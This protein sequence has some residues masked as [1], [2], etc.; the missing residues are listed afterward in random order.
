MKL[1]DTGKKLDLL[2]NKGWT[3]WQGRGS[4]VYYLIK[5]DQKLNAIDNGDKIL[6]SYQILKSGQIL[7]GNQ[8]LKS[9]QILK[10]DKF[11]LKFWHCWHL[12]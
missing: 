11:W 1:G 6:K 9:D 7:K 2:F 3:G 4:G 10:G 5:G 12:I 8:I